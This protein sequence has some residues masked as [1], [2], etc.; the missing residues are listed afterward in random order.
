MILCCDT[1]TVEI[2]GSEIYCE[3]VAGEN[4]QLFIVIPGTPNLYIENGCCTKHPFINGCL[5]FQVDI[6]SI[7]GGSPGCLPTVFHLVLLMEEIR[8]HHLRCTKPCK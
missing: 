2:H 8:K 4:H 3:A 5:G 6:Q 7:F 1:D